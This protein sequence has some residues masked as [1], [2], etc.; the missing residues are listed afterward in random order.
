MEER[1]KVKKQLEIEMPEDDFIAMMKEYARRYLV[2]VHVGDKHTELQFYFKPEMDIDIAES[3]GSVEFTIWLTS[4]W[5]K[6]YVIDGIANDLVR[7]RYYEE[8]EEV[9]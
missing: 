7:I 1:W 8:V 2:V 6:R 9:E 3:H 4:R 5:Q